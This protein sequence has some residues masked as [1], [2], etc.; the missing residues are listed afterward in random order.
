MQS[1]FSPNRYSSAYH[2]GHTSSTD[3]IIFGTCRWNL[4]HRVCEP[5]LIDIWCEC[6]QHVNIWGQ[7][8]KGTSRAHHWRSHHDKDE[9]KIVI[10]ELF[11]NFQ[12]ESRFR[13]IFFEV[14][15]F[16]TRIG[17]IG[18]GVIQLNKPFNES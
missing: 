18:L 2:F 8:V 1:L 9:E 12:L 15:F 4:T 6:N 14:I 11:F 3:Y 16:Y 13:N 17:I 5:T 10:Q 7:G